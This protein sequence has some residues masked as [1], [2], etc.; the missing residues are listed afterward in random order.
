[1]RRLTRIHR[2][3][4]TM[5]RTTAIHRDDATD[6]TNNDNSPRWRDAATPTAVSWPVV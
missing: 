1:M 4:A 3:A 6:A 5:R 2:D